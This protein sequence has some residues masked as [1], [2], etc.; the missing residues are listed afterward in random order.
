MDGLAVTKVFEVGVIAEF[1]SQLEP[2]PWPG[3][4]ANV[5]N[6]F[7]DFE[8]GPDGTLEFIKRQDT[9]DAVIYRQTWRS[10]GLGLFRHNVVSSNS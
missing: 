7:Q 9:K 3:H 4:I 5:I 8:I 6:L 1:V 2:E 10:D